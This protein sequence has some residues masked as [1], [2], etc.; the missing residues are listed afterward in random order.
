MAVLP[1]DPFDAVRWVRARADKRGYVTVDGREYVAGPAWHSRELL[2]G[3]RAATVEILADRGRRAALLPR[4]WG[5]GEPV[6][7][8][9]M[10]GG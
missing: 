8:A 4:A 5:P 3:V 2:V 7:N 1:P 9:L 10:Q 6:R